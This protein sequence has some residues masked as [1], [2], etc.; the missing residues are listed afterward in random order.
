[1]IAPLGEEELAGLTFERKKGARGPAVT[2]NALPTHAASIV[3]FDGGTHRHRAP[4]TQETAGILNG[5]DSAD[6]LEQRFEKDKL[7]GDD[8]DY[9]FRPP[10]GYY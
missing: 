6:G 7:F 3:S 8:D 2:R 5:E 4:S 9:A 1:L 10:Y